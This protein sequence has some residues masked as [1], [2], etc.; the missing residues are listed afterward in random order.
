ME[1]F[2]AKLS[3]EANEKKPLHFFIS[4]SVQGMIKLF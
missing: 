1:N 3:V 4:D 2:W